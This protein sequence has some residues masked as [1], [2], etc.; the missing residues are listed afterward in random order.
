M[1]LRVRSPEDGELKL[2]PS[3]LQGGKGNFIESERK[4][5]NHLAK[6]KASGPGDLFKSVNSLKASAK[7]HPVGFGGPR[8]SH[9]G[10][11]THSECILYAW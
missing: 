5:R 3:L 7:E 2:V 9:S 1:S 6:S 8:K 10:F 4:M 11:Q